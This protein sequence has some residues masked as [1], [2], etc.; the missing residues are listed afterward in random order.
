MLLWTWGCRYIFK[1]VFSFPLDI[2]WKVELLDHMMV[3]FLILWGSSILFSIVAIP[4]YNPN[5]AQVFSFLHTH[6]SIC[7][8]LSLMIAILTGMRWYFTILFCIS[9]MTSDAE[10]LF[11]YLLIFHVSFLENC[12][13]RSFVHF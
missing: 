13:S 9:L 10:H 11:M 2:F 1:L 8:L 6:T 4:I 5:S 7:Y 12:L 3:L